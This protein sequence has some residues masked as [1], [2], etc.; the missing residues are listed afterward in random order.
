MREGLAQELCDEQCPMC[1]AVCCG[2][3]EK[4]I[5]ETEA[6]SVFSSA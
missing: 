4:V 5:T 1:E 2:A 6:S 3:V